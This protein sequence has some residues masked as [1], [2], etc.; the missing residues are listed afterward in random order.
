MSSFDDKEND[1]L[2]LVNS[3]D[4]PI[5][6]LG[7]ADCHVGD[8]TLHRAFSVFL[9]ND[10][11]QV[12]IQQRSANKPLWPL[13]WANSCCSHPRVGEETAD[14]ANRRIEEELGVSSS[15]TYLYKFEYQARWDADKSEHELCSV[16]AGHF[17]RELTVDRG[18]IADWKLVTPAELTAAIAADPDAYSPWLKLEW[19]RITADFLDDILNKAA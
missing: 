10:A 3:N 14:A 7:K 13:I 9:F 1:L 18:E 16:F 2:I 19:E 8:G 6:E 4:E 11:G 5:G 12:L 15:L 17:D